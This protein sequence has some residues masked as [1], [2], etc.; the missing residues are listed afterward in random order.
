MQPDITPQKFDDFLERLGTQ[1]HERR[2]NYFR[3]LEY[4]LAL[5]LLDAQPGQEV[6]EIGAGHVAA[7][8]LYLADKGCRVIASDLKSADEQVLHYVDLLRQRLGFPSANLSLKAAD[9]RE[10]PF[11]SGRFDRVLCVSTLEHTIPFED[12]VIAKEIG[13]VLAPGG[14][15]VITVPFNH[16]EHIEFNDAHGEEYLQR[17]YNEYSL[18]ERILTPTGLHMERALIF[19]EHDFLDGDKW[20]QMP[21][22]E[23]VAFCRHNLEHWERYWKVYYELD[24]DDFH[25]DREQLADS[26]QQRAGLVALRLVKS[27]LSATL[28]SKYI[29]DPLKSFRENGRYVRPF[30]EGPVGARLLDIKVHNMYGTPL[31]AFK[32]GETLLIS[33]KIEVRGRTGVV[34]RATF[35]DDL[36]NCVARVDLPL[37]DP[38]GLND[39][40]L[41]FGMLNLGAGTYDLTLGLWD[42]DKPSPL[43]PVPLDVHEPAVQL[44]VGNDK[45][46]LS[47]PV[48]L[49]Y[50]VRF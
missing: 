13:R 35:E 48:Y 26:V 43:P 34:F 8:S 42:R 27:P 3:W 15:A 24:Q 17:H 32:S 37:A 9:A 45:P 11:E 5:S 12:S 7:T 14:L 47:G 10:L 39:L 2:L 19:G 30:D 46:G 18:R 20:R 6:L 44:V 33:A 28:W 40:E 36:G 25:I 23:Q 1:E 31:D 4:P 41:T 22:D 50:S 29:Y 21:R 16:G 49:P 38:Q